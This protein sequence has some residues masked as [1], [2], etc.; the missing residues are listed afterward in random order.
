MGIE[1]PQIKPAMFELT[2][3]Y[4]SHSGIVDCAQAVID[5][6]VHFRPDTIDVLR[7]Q[8]S[9]IKGLEPIWF[10]GEEVAFSPEE[11]FAG[12]EYESLL[13]VTLDC[14]DTSCKGRA[15]VN[16]ALNN[17]CLFQILMPNYNTITGILV[18]DDA[19]RDRLRVHVGER[20]LILYGSSEIP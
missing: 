16:L 13:V 5:L 11:F 6:I 8:R 9:V 17:V 20:A 4:R 7:P 19:S 10:S 15:T 12:L 2:T 14:A 3:N 1:K 18:R